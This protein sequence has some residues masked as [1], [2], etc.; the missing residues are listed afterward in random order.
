M[1]GNWSQSHHHSAQQA[2]Q[3]P[4]IRNMFRRSPFVALSLCG[5]A[6]LL[7]C[8][9]FSLLA[10]EKKDVSRAGSD[11][12]KKIMETYGGR[13]VMRDDTPPSAPQEA[14]KKFKMR[15]GFAIDIMATEPNVEQPL[16]M[17]WDSR[18]RLWVTL[19][20]QYQFPEGLKIVSYDQHLRAVFDKVPEP[21]PKGVKG[22]DKVVVFEDTDGDGFFDKHKTVIDG[23]NIATAAI[24][25]AGGIWVMNA[26]YLLFYPD[27]NDDDIP[28]AD[29]EVALKGFGIQDTHSVANSIQF[30]PDGWLY[31]ANGST[32]IGTVSSK[33]SKNIHF[34][35]QHIWRYH[36]RT[37]V[38]EIY[39]E[40][41]GNTFST[42]IDAQG[43]Y[44]SGTNSADRGMHY[45]QGQSGSK[46][47]GKHGPP[48]NPFS[49]GFFD[50]M[51]TKSDGKRFNQAYCIYD[52]DLMAD[53][54][55]GRI[56]SANS[57]QNMVYVSR[58]IPIGSTFHVEDDPE[59]LRSSDRWFRPVDCKVAPDG[60]VYLADWYDT[61]LSHVSP[62]DDWSKKDGR[63]YRIR[64]EGKVPKLE[65]FDL[66]TADTKALVAKLSHPHK[67]F[68]KQAALELGWRKD[69]DTLPELEKMARDAKNPHALDALFALHMLGG[70]T[71]DLALDLLKHAD[72]YVRRW[73]V[74][75]VG[76]KGDATTL[77]GS[78]LKE[79]A[80]REEHPE[81]RT[82]LLASAK[83][84]PAETALPIAQVMMAR[85]SDLADQRIP[86]M[87]WWVFES[88]AVSDRDALLALFSDPAAW[89]MKLARAYGIQNLAKRWAMEGGKENF[90]ACAKLLALAKRN[91]DRSL[92]I[93]GIA[94]A[95]EGGKI[96][97]LPDSIS[98]P[99][100]AFLKSRLDTDLALAVK[101]GNADAVKKAVK[102]V[103]DAKAPGVQ[104]AALVTALAEAGKKEA[105]PAFVTVLKSPGDIGL[106]RTVLSVA[107]KF[108]D[109][110]LPELVA[111][112]FEGRFAGDAALR[113]TAHRMLA[114]RKEWA[115]IM[116]DELEERRIKSEYVAPDV[117]RQMLAFGDK[118]LE[119]RIHK[120]WPQK[121]TTLSDSQKQAEAER[122]KTVLR[123][124]P[125]D[126]EK[127]KVIYTQRCAICH[128]LFG[129]GGKIGPDLTGYERNSP[130]FWITNMLA[131]SLE[132]REGFG[133]YV[134]KLKDGQVLMG[135]LEKQ[136]A[137][138]I[139]L[140]D[141]AAQKHTARTDDIESMDASPI[142][143]MPEGQL[144]GVSDA[145]LRDLFAYL[146]KP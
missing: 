70:L 2:H 9:S 108:D 51:K 74:R 16:Y 12:V 17:S 72:P 48:L 61:R 105:V 100:D 23:L 121:N 106:K 37:K 130:E 96:P 1:A 35:G 127:G 144:M 125:G 53:T 136:D 83:R 142:S 54:L 90:E 26:P 60:G 118:N 110:S 120:V 102:I 97:Q 32:T 113:D 68:R 55:G 81:V 6:A 43:R 76:D 42:E 71:D 47:F 40:G 78:A 138:G 139:T 128:T 112:G 22:A 27:A 82:Q 137:G 45:E 134:V 41:G 30:G 15:D 69:K 146:M 36:P 58:R 111:K 39:A 56:V 129:E 115:S 94:S 20:R 18:G 13:G 38:F 64:P 133:A 80:A 52:G 66:H 10:Q 8:C 109:K 101:T 140:R 59:L 126:P 25:G 117:V 88:K 31:G 21:P 63:I 79:L 104:R 4:R 19:Y 44:F 77:V 87:I 143:L 122:I 119:A 141:L 14:V 50:H 98:E 24:K 131:P 29:P 116:L 62:V 145:D 46:N 91:D 124:G 86:L 11:Q 7:F 95:F 85:E 67:W 73:V 84:L 49:F 114:S 89:D 33:V 123:G 28:D 3:P 65:P 34:E 135:I 75:C 132:I 92:I 107:A 99:L 57:L 5:S 93:E 103:T